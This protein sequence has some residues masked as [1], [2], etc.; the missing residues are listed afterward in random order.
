MTQFSFYGEARAGF[1]TRKRGEDCSLH[2]AHLPLSGNQG[3]LAAIGIGQEGDSGG[4]GAACSA[5]LVSEA[6]LSMLFQRMLD[7]AEKGITLSE[8][9]DHTPVENWWSS[10]FVR[11]GEDFPSL[12]RYRH[13]MVN[14][15]GFFAFCW[16]DSD[17][18]GVFCRRKTSDLRE[19]PL[20]PLDGEV[21]REATQFTEGDEIVGCFF[22]HRVSQTGVSFKKCSF[23][24]GLPSAAYVALEP[25]QGALNEWMTRNEHPDDVAVVI[26]SKT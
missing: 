3:M 6:V 5:A 22:R 7:A 4:I 25:R 16:V 21:V 10:L 20:L 15:A 1:S 11:L 9:F 2:T 13:T 24:I 17:L 12:Q 14:P 26:I 18:Y 23:G 19:Q 8:L